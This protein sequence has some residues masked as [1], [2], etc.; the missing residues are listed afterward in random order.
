MLKIRLIAA[1]VAIVMTLIT[2]Y[3]IPILIAAYT[4]WTNTLDAQEQ[5]WFL[6]SQA[7]LGALIALTALWQW[8]K[9]RSRRKN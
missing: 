8:K 3:L 9:K 5:Q 7:A 1:L 4:G 6:Y 2:I